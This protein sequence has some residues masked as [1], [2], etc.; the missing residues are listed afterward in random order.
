MIRF[1]ALFLFLS[2]PLFAAPLDTLPDPQHEARAVALGG[3][4]R[5]VVCQAESI[6]D[7]AATMA[8]DLRRL[9][10]ERIAAGATD[11]EIRAY[12]RAR[13]GDFILLRP[14]VQANTTVLWMAPLVVLLTAGV[15]IVRFMRR[16]GLG[17]K[18]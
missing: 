13:Y 11:D 12:V 4:F 2:G 6:N 16:R 14:P 5:C 10:R 17:R 8:R 15:F 7:S 18:V 1:L 9:V 3:E